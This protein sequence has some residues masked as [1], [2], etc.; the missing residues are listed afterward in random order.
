MKTLIT[1]SEGV[2]L[3]ELVNHP[4]M[5]IVLSAKEFAG[6]ISEVPVEMLKL[7][8]KEEPHV[9]GE[10]AYFASSRALREEYYSGQLGETQ[11]A[12]IR[13]ELERRHGRDWHSA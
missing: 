2:V 13:A 9:C 7:F 6:M 11:M 3:S 12:N 5:V 8:T 1:N 10:P 4:G